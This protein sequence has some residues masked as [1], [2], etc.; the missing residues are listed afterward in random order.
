MHLFWLTSFCPKTQQGQVS[1]S[2]VDTRREGSPCKNI[3]GVQNQQKFFFTWS[4]TKSNTFITYKHPSA[5]WADEI[6]EHSNMSICWVQWYVF[7]LFCLRFIFAWRQTFAWQIMNMFPD[8]LSLSQ[9][10]AYSGRETLFWFWNGSSTV[11][12]IIAWLRG[13]H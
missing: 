11:A 9:Y 7:I 3:K 13:S 8:I 6:K 1:H 12:L 10:V 2:R 4:H 5:A